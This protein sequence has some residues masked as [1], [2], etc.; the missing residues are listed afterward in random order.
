MCRLMKEKLF[1]V[2]SCKLIFSIVEMNHHPS[3]IAVTS[4]T[5]CPL[6]MVS[7]KENSDIRL[8]D[9]RVFTIFH[10]TILRG[11]LALDFVPGRIQ[12]NL[13]QLRKNI[14]ILPYISAFRVEKSS[15]SC[16][17]ISGSTKNLMSGWSLYDAMKT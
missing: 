4:K 14:G 2:S 3:P 8:I 7:C 16:F 13:T 15:A 10:M 17:C 9:R 1:Y 11:C 5:S 12:N 6:S